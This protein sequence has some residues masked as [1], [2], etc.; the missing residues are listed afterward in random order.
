MNSRHIF[1]VVVIA[2]AAL[3]V[4]VAL[5]AST[6]G[7]R[8]PS[9][10]FKTRVLD[11][12]AADKWIEVRVLEQ[13]KGKT[14]LLGDKFIVRVLSTTKTYNKFNK[15]QA[16]T[17]WLSRVQADDLVS[18]LGEYKSS[19]GTLWADRLVNRSR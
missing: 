13:T 8:V 9:T 11:K 5:L 1:L 19:D 7:A 15:L 14:N 17:S 2:V 16:T 6:A 18:A 10:A 12:S 4:I 3:A